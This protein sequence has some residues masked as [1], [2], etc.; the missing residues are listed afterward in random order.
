MKD[1][2]V[3]HVDG[4]PRTGSRL[5]RSIGVLVS[6]PNGTYGIGFWNTVNPFHDRLHSNPEFEDHSKPTTAIRTIARLEE[7]LSKIGDPEDHD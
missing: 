1:R 7:I 5:I 4:N 2:H 3:S 6:N